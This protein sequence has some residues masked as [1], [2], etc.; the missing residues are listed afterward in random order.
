MFKKV[1]LISFAAITVLGLAACG[2]SDE[3]KTEINSD[4]NIEAKTGDNATPS[5]SEA[6][7]VANEEEIA[8]EDNGDKEDDIW[9]YYEDA[10][11]EGDFKGL[12]TNIEKVTVTNEAPTLENEDANASA[13][14]V[15]FRI[16]NT[17]DDTKFDTY[18][19]QATLVTSTGEQVEADMMVS[20]HIGGTIDKG[21]VKEGDVIFYLDRGEADKIEWIKL[22][23]HSSDED[24]EESA[25]YDENYTEEE[26]E[27][28][29]K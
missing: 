28:E 8:D 2:D 15:K 14:G 22:E 6:E 17:T 27:L 9:T 4:N 25:D 10:T 21:V 24:L 19:D 11:W 3:N 20:D 7:E 12:K 29:L 13:V 1:S 16:E 23:W 5:S 26:V 18:P